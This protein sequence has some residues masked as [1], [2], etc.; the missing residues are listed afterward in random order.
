MGLHQRVGRSV[1]KMHE[2][3]RP[4]EASV[5]RDPARV[6]RNVAEAGPHGSRVTRRSALRYSRSR[7][8]NE[9]KVVAA[10][11]RLQCRA[12]GTGR[13]RP[14]APEPPGL[15]GGAPVGAGGKAKP[16]FDQIENE[17]K[18]GSPTSRRKAKQSRSETNPPKC[19]G[20]DRFGRILVRAL[21]GREAR[22]RRSDQA[23][24][25]LLVVDRGAISSREEEGRFAFPA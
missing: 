22:R 15:L 7:T 5:V 16:L 18:A 2:G 23:R 4:V 10:W 9:T 6:K 20:R 25:V 3:P 13:Y 11:E 1:E 24:L 19:S 12:G 14:A 17:F 8:T 21:A